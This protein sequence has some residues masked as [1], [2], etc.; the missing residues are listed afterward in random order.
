MRYQL[1]CVPDGTEADGVTAKKRICISITGFTS[2]KTV[3]DDLKTAGIENTH[4]VPQNFIAIR[5]IDLLKAQKVLETGTPSDTVPYEIWKAICEYADQ[6]KVTEDSIRHKLGETIWG[7]L[8]P[9]QKVCVQKAVDAKKFYIADEM[10]TGKTF[11]CLAICKYFEDQWPVLV[12]CPSSLRF[13]WRSEIVRWLNLPETDV[14]VAKNSKHYGINHNAKHKFLVI[15][16]SLLINKGVVDTLKSKRYQTVV[17]DEAHY[18]K[19]MYSKRASQACL[20]AEHATVKLLLSG[21][22]FSY[23]SEMYQQL[24]ILNPALFPKFFV[25][26]PHVECFAKRYCKPKQ[27]M[28]RGKR[29]VWTFHGYERH[30]ELNALFSTFMIRRRKTDILTQLP[31]KNRICIT[32]DPLPSK[33]LTEIE[34]LLKHTKGKKKKTGENEQ[35]EG[36]EGEGSDMMKYMESFRLTCSYKIQNVVNFVKEQILEDYMAENPQSKTLIF[37]HHSE[38][39]QALEE[40]MQH[41][42]MPYFVISGATSAQK[43]EEYKDSFQGSDEYRVGLL[44]ITAAGVGLTLTAASTEVFT[45]ILFGPNDHL[46]AEDRAHRLGQKSI[47]NIF[48]LIQPNTTDDINFG[49]IRKKERESSMMLD[50]TVGALPSRR[51]AASEVNTN[52]KRQKVSE[53]DKRETGKRETEQKPPTIFARRSTHKVF[54]L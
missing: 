1:L 8:H 28:I 35:K 45:E 17:F 44:S 31:E 53:T 43:R 36:E 7:N 25:N 30:E 38:M 22:P 46:Q 10:G 12:F 19:S 51:M 42:K 32:L 39:Q 2:A 24:K 15:P 11:Q 13:T 29:L 4:V 3:M 5:L 50:G 48:Y 27:S 52:L 33:Q 6:P 20:V 54:Q 34:K 16:Y 49:L 21:T 9:Y 47:V 40:L 37:F 18:V 23:P 26:Q 41:C 14:L